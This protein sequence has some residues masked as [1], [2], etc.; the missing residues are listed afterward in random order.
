MSQWEWWEIEVKKRGL[1]PAEF[2]ETFA[3]SSGAG[4][5]NVNKVATKVTLIYIPTQTAVS[6]QEARSQFSNRVLARQR[7]LDQYDARR[8]QEKARLKGEREKKRRRNRGRPRGLKE[9]I[10]KGK[11]HRSKIKE[12]RRKPE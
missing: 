5:Q 2:Q 7:F 9:K 12:N 1:N 11:K 3:C 8:D 6:C 4:G 10:L